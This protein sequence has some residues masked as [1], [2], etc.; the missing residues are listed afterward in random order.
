M[1]DQDVYD[2]VKTAYLPEQ[3]DEILR[4]FELLEAFGLEYY[5]SEFIPIV[6]NTDKYDP[7]DMRLAFN[8]QLIKSLNIVLNEHNVY[9]KSEINLYIRNEI[10]SSIYL[11]QHLNDYSPILQ[12]LESYLENDDKLIAILSHTCILSDI[13]I[14]DSVETF[15][16]SF[17][18]GLYD[19]IMANHPDQDDQSQ[20]DNIHVK[21]LKLFKTFLH[22]QTCLGLELIS[23]GSP[24]GLEPDYYFKHL[25]I[26]KPIVQLALDVLSCILVSQAY[27]FPTMAYR[28]H[29]SVYI[30]DIN[31][32]TQ[33]DTIVTHMVGDFERYKSETSHE[34][35]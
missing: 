15:E 11:L 6:T 25:D 34:Q 26:N 35:V 2:Y 20:I 23:S 4:G 14:S 21:N 10:L 32:F 8:S 33:I 5:D 19:F 22:E 3:A 18:K 7:D 29:A 1:L 16:P 24:I 28:K 30:Q 9:L 31:R 27:Q 17:L 12:I 13:V